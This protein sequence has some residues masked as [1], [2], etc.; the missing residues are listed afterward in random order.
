MIAG[1]V[2]PPVLVGIGPTPGSGSGAATRLE[3]SYNPV[4]RI[5]GA[6]F[7]PLRSEPGGMH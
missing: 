2:V 6:W 4:S 7:L 3:M 5:A 1:L